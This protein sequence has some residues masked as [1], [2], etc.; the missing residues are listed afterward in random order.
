MTKKLT[1]H[2]L[3]RIIKECVNNL[4]KE[5]FNDKK[6]SDEI[7]RHGGL[8]KSDRK[9]GAGIYSNYDLQNS[10]YQGYLSPETIEEI[11]NCD[12]IFYLNEYLLF[13]ND[14]GAIVV[15][16][17]KNEIINNTPWENKVRNRNNKW[18]ENTEYP[19]FKKDIYVKPNK[20]NTYQRRNERK[21]Y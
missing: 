6:I 9:Y 20:L 13:T 12:L 11:D 21:K 15:K 14:G 1:E 3:N 16:Q 18:G 8:K 2:N 10:L 4:L 19:F 5:S 17:N 7:K